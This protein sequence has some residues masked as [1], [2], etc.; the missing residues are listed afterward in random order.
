[1]EVCGL[2]AG[3]GGEEVEAVVD[4]GALPAAAE[5]SPIGDSAWGLIVGDGLEQFSPDD[6]S[7][8]VAALDSRPSL[9]SIALV[10]SITRTKLA[11]EQIS[12][13]T[14]VDQPIEVAAGDLLMLLR[15]ALKRVG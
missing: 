6:L 2:D 10:A 5:P 8:L 15:T 7:E 12:T 9:E 11:M 4:T 3:A 13:L 14:A 1:M